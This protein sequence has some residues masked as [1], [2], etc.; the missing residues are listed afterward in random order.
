MGCRWGL[1]G[2]ERKE[3]VCPDSLLTE[4]RRENR[5]VPPYRADKRSANKRPGGGQ[6]VQTLMQK[7]EKEEQGKGG[8]APE[9]GMGKK[10]PGRSTT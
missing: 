6:P 5:G 3:S 4:K 10:R 2:C 8:K 1:G 9:R 7:R